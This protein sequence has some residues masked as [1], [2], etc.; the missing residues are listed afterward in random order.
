MTHSAKAVQLS[1]S[2]NVYMLRCM[3]REE[4]DLLHR[5]VLGTVPAGTASDVAR[6]SISDIQQAIAILD[7]R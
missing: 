7:K 1:A 6:Q 2:H 5:K 4:R 3:L